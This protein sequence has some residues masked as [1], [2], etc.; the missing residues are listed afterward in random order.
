MK[1]KQF[2]KNIK[3]LGQFFSENA[4][5]ISHLEELELIA[6]EMNFA[7]EERASTGEFPIPVE[8]KVDDN[9]IALFSDGACR[10]N[11]GPGSWGILGQ[12]SDG[13]VLFEA[14][15]VEMRTTN[16][17]MEL[18]GAINGLEI[19]DDEG[20]TNNALFLFSDSKYVVDGAEKWMAGWKKRGW[21]KADKKEPENIDLWKR[22]DDIIHRFS[23]LN[24]RW[25]KGHAGHP[26]NEFC[27]Q[28]AN[29]ALDE[30]GL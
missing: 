5:A 21:K 17:R 18:L 1:K 30:A 4:E 6:K 24:Y 11:P 23:N 26:Q 2:N 29:Q 20:L 7:V 16:N 9:S 3:E 27:D 14:S 8:L 19:L 28:L 12:R 10:G 15:G 22:L 25:V 13:S